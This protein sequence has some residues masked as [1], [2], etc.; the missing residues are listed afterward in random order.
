MERSGIPVWIAT[1][2]LLA[3]GVACA[4]DTNVYLS[5]GLGQMRQSFDTHEYVLDVPAQGLSGDDTR[6]RAWDVGVGY[7]INEFLATELSYLDAGTGKRRLD[8]ATPARIDSH[9]TGLLASVVPQFSFS[10]GSYFYAR[11]GA[12]YADDKV[13]YKY[14]EASNF[15]RS[16]SIRGTTWFAGLGVAY[17]V[18]DRWSIGLEYV[19]SGALRQDSSVADNYLSGARLGFRFDF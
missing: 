6:D 16:D 1:A 11:I 13:T 8:G 4:Q 17:Q 15:N 7:Q 3:T 12:L 9:V 2:T 5:A 19:R 18:L 14:P 10:S